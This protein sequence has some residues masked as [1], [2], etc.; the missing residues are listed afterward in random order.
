MSRNRIPLAKGVSKTPKSSTT[1]NVLAAIREA[2]KSCEVV[3]CGEVFLDGGKDHRGLEALLALVVQYGKSYR[4]VIKVMIKS[5]DPELR[6]LGET[7]RLSLS[8]LDFPVRT[9]RGVVAKA[10]SRAAELEGR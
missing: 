2:E 7:M 6:T 3:L 8:V 4:P 1:K 9:L 5:G 10:K